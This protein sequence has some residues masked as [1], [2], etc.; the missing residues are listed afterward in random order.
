MRRGEIYWAELAPRPG[1][2][3]TGRRPVVLVSRDAL[4]RLAAWRSVNV[5]PL[6]TSKRRAGPTAVAL[7]RGTAGLAE[8]S[9]ALCHQVT[10]I[11]RSKLSALIG[12]L[13]PAELARLEQGLKLALELD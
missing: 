10:T 2:E 8:D 4:N 3:Q 12:M 5:V 7:S 13:P 9:L 11:D 1:S 6:S